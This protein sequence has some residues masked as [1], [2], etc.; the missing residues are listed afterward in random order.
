MLRGNPLKG[1]LP[2]A[3]QNEK[4]VC[5]FAIRIFQKATQMQCV[6]ILYAPLEEFH[7][8]SDG[9]KSRSEEVGKSTERLGQKTDAQK[10]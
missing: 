7:S 4:K 6:C 5:I 9:K 8:V 3:S 1:C 2:K 10:A